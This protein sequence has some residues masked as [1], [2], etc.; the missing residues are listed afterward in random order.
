MNLILVSLQADKPPAG[1]AHGK[2]SQ[3]GA[4]NGT[5][6]GS[7]PAASGY[8]HAQP[9]TGTH[10]YECCQ[11]EVTAPGDVSQMATVDWKETKDFNREKRQTEDMGRRG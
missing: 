7:F 3:D 1:K 10:N 8:G 11:N 6:Y 2:T 9:T 4:K 5:N